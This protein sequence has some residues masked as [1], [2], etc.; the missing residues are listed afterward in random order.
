MSIDGE[1]CGCTPIRPVCPTGYGLY[2]RIEI[3]RDYF[4]RG[5][6]NR[7]GV[8]RFEAEYQH[9]VVDQADDAQA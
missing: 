7:A 5:I 6:I 4:E 1:P 8:K 9:H 2:N 3:A